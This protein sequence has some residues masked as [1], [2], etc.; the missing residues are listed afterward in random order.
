VA[1]SQPEDF[2]LIARR[3]VAESTLVQ[4][5]L[6]AKLRALFHL[7][8]A[9]VTPLPR[10]QRIEKQLEIPTLAHAALAADSVAWRESR[11]LSGAR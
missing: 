9:L 4:R 8:Q 2:E 1:G 5:T 7:A 6:G 3:Y 10:L 11:G